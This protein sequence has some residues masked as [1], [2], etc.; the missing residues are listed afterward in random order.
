MV[1]VSE[2]IENNYDLSINKYRQVEREV[3]EYRSTSEILKDIT[4]LNDKE[5]KVFSILKDM[6]GE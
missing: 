5:T 1:P 3:V 6:I 4:D 2:I